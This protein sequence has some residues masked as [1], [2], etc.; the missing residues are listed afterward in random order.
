[1][2]LVGV[3][4][5]EIVGQAAGEFDDQFAD[6]NLPFVFRPCGEQIMVAADP[7]H[8]WRVLENLFSNAAKYALDGTR[9]FA[10]ITQ[11]VENST[12]YR[13]EAE[14]QERQVVLSLKN[15][16]AIPIDLLPDALTEQFIRGDRTRLSDGSGLGLYIAK[17]LMELMG[18]ELTV[19]ASG[20]LFDVEIT[21][22]QY[23][24]IP[25]EYVIYR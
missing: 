15:T 14:D 9:V 4:L 8:L 7:Q 1:M 23:Q 6:R 19:R 21:F 25:V 20:D 22:N 18:G 16:S 24:E 3:D 2:T 13:N 17:S 12:K 11:R 5:A 10:E